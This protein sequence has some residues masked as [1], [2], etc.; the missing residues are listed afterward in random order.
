MNAG[1]RSSGQAVKRILDFGFWI[2]DSGGVYR[3][4]LAF[5]LVFCTILLAGPADRIIAVVANQIILQSEVDAGVELLKFQVPSDSAHPRPSDSLLRSQVLDQLIS[6]QVILEEARR[7]TLTVT[8]DQVDA[9][10]KDAMKNLK[11]RFGT[12]DSFKLALEREGLTEA[13]LTQR[14]R[15][16]ITQR[17][18]AQQLLQKHNLLENIAVTPTE[19]RQFYSTHRDSFGSIPGRVKLAHV[20]IIPRPSEK[21]E[22]KAY[23][24][25]IEAWVGLTKSGWDFEATAGSFSTDEE[26]RRQA[27][28]LGQVQRGEMPEEIDSVLFGLRAGEISK[29]FR[30]RLG[31][32]I[33][34]REG[35]SGGT[36][37]ARTILITVPTTEADTVRARE[38]A[39]QVRQRAMSGEDFAS[40]VKEFSDDPGTKLTGGELGEFFIKGLAPPYSEAV[41]N[42]KAG[43]VS[44]PIQSEHGIHVIKVLERSEEQIPTYEELQDNIRNYLQAQK[45]KAKLDDF[46]K[47]Y[48][49][50]I[51]IQ[52]Y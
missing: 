13:G 50:K 10:L 41:Q 3:R 22:Q 32:Q 1:K 20:L 49:A 21:D 19:A 43:E 38:L 27:G 52:R 11:A 23:E 34:K 36:A 40:L 37:R 14:Y 30:S 4:L 29:P 44:Q 5:P 33:L 2:L 42:L 6:D 47:L 16:E 51:S 45:L 7:E 39:G 12:P 28:S 24:Q 48:S 17:A 18:T 26:I 31:W 8:K 35:G 25:I 9:E 46:V 15:E